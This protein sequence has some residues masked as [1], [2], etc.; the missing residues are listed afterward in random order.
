MTSSVAFFFLFMVVFKS[1]DITIGGVIVINSVLI[2]TTTSNAIHR[3]Q[4]D[5]SNVDRL[6]PI[7]PHHAFLTIQRPV[8]KDIIFIIVVGCVVVS[9]FICVVISEV[10][11]VVIQLSVCAAM[12]VFIFVAVDKTIRIG[13]S[14]R[15]VE[16]T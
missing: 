3:V 15:R 8:E 5:P 6:L 14:L 4:Q 16:V 10:I 11:G 2:C 12:R 9:V 7:H 1:Y 13:A